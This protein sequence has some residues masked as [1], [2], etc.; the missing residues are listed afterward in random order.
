MEKNL[1]PQDDENFFQGKTRDLCYAT[2]ET[3][4]YTT[5]LSSG[6]E[7]KNIVFR[8]A[9]NEINKSIEITHQKV[10]AGDL[11]PI[12]FYMEKNLMDIKLLSEYMEI[13]KR[14]VKKH[15]LPS[16]FGKLNNETLE[17]YAEIF[18]I[19]IEELIKVL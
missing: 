15:L 18:N 13:S 7:P 8:Q 5:V 17:K 10:I 19:S 16:E 14:H 11:S 9:W 3:G 6:W 1:V 2:D 4:K 12:A